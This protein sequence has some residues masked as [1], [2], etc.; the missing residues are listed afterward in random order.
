MQL[1]LSP[2]T[3]RDKGF[4]NKVCSGGQRLRNIVANRS[5]LV[6]AKKWWV[7]R[8]E[9][10]HTLISC[11]TNSASGCCTCSICMASPVVFP[12]FSTI[13]R[14]YHCALLVSSSLF[15]TFGS[16]VLAESC[17]LSRQESARLTNCAVSEAGGRQPR[18]VSEKNGKSSGER[19]ELH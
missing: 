4:L 19:T 6:V 2:Y 10:S 18:V 13:I 17:G 5:N 1:Y 3:A 12:S 8:T 11:C 9:L 14:D 16:S 15:T 7:A